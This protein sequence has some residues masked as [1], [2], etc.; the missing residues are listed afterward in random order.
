MVRRLRNRAS[1]ALNREPIF[2]LERLCPVPMNA[3]ATVRSWRLAAAFASSL[4]G[5]CGGKSIVG[6][7]AAVTLDAP[8]EVATAGPDAAAGD[9][10]ATV[11]VTGDAGAPDAGVAPVV[12]ARAPGCGAARLTLLGTA[13]YWTELETGVV[14]ALDVGAG[15]ATPTLVATN[16][17]RPGAI[18]A[19]E[20][21]LYWSN[22]GSRALCAAPFGAPDGGTSHACDQPVLTA[23]AIVHGLIAGGTFLYYGAGPS[24]YKLSRR[25]GAPA[26]LAS[27]ATC[28]PSQPMAFALGGDSLYQTDSQLMFVTREKIDGTQLGNDPCAVAD[29]G[30]PAQ[31][32]IPETMTHSQGALLLDAIA[33]AN[34]EVLWADHASINARTTGP[35]AGGT[36]RVVA[37]TA[38][39]N[40][41]T[42]FVV[43]GDRVYFGETDD[44]GGGDTADTIQVAPLGAAEAGSDA[45]GTV[46]AKG[47]RHAGS[48][49]ADATH[50]YWTTHAPSA[51][52]GAADDCAI[53]SLAK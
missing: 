19:D 45:T 8:T 9:A 39:A 13:L 38:G 21:G 15:S 31:I 4:L 1:R 33:V 11:D 51:T 28:R 22:E 34:G 5:G 27:F 41:V 30:P 10:D 18:A 49:V 24:T 48:F 50:V 17:P 6:H 43:A 23:P 26:L 53:V 7:D 46:V 40:S 47:Q 2:P 36:T 37:E 44:F 20:V 32:A 12:L 35:V 3:F 14:K 42:G 52:A 16:Q 29:A 25:G